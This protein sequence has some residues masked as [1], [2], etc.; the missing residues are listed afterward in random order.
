MRAKALF[1]LPFA[2]LALASVLVAWW[3]PSVGDYS[4]D[5][6]P[7]IAALAHGRLGDFFA[8]QPLMGGLSVLVRAPLAALAVALGHADELTVYRVGAVPC[9]AAAGALGLHLARRL[10]A[11]GRPRGE[12]LV[13][14]ALVLLNPMTF[15]A[16]RFG[17]PEELLGGALCVAAVLV[18]SRDRPLLAGLALGCAVGTKQW[19][20]IAILPVLLV[21]PGRRA[22]LL[23]VAAVVGAALWLP[24]ALG[25][26]GTFVERNSKADATHWVTPT[27][28]WWAAASAEGREVFDGVETL[29]VTRKLDDPLARVPRPLIVLVAIGLALLAWRR[30]QG[31]LDVADALALLA[32]VFLARCVLEPANV[33]YYHVPLLLSLA[34]WE[35]HRRRG[36]PVV[37][38]LAA[39][40]TWLT[41]RQF[42][43]RTP[44]LV[45]VLYLAWTA[46]LA[47]GLALEVYAPAA[48]RRL[49][50]RR[51]AAPSAGR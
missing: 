12:Q 21:A 41:Y 38:L 50:S 19:A 3:T 40:A 11:R 8:H 13:V 9:V 20:V 22:R 31:R 5:A 32:L 28:V 24:L 25:D 45:N 49:A 43:S 16:L 2:L 18:A 35:A 46:P 34:G 17:H 1:V 26:A 29:V 27:N 36:L 47:A 30:R 15:Q 48:W 42:P 14:A 33:G 51:T 6:G 4:F 39:L 10:A 23:G 37:T 44:D 7:G